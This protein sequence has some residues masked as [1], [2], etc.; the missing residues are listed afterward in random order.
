LRALDQRSHDQRSP[1]ALRQIETPDRI[2]TYQETRVMCRQLEA[3]F[4]RKGIR[5][6]SGREAF[7]FGI[8]KKKVLDKAHSTH[9]RSA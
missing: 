4:I 5:W 2:P 7:M 6:E 1:A 3:Y 9:D 8:P